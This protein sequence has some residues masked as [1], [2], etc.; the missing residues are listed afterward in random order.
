MWSLFLFMGGLV[1]FLMLMLGMMLIMVNIP[2]LQAWIAKRFQDKSGHDE[3][4][5]RLKAIENR[6]DRI[7]VQA[8][9]D[10]HYEGN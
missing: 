4:E 3:L 8:P 6:L 7:E 1:L 9:N 2:A 5:I 10:L